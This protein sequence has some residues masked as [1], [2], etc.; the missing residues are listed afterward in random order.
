M[1]PIIISMPDETRTATSIKV[2]DISKGNAV[3]TVVEF[4]YVTNKTGEGHEEYR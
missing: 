3:V 2:M 1:E 4:L